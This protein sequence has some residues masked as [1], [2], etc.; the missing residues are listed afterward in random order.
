MIK[1][2]TI[3]SLLVL[4]SCINITTAQNNQETNVE[5]EKNSVSSNILGTG[6][7]IGISYER[8]L[9]ERISLEVGVGLIGF[10]AGITYY[11]IKVVP[12]RL[13][14]YLGAKITTHSMVDGE[15][16]TVAYIPF[17]LTWFS[18]FRMNFGFDVGP[19]VTKHISPGYFGFE[20]EPKSY[21]FTDYGVF[22]NLKVG[23]RF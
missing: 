22:G 10:G 19:A 8:L 15:H 5:I 23:F 9:F 18:N 12:N 1:L 6:S 3:F 17:G 4:I 2:K 7:Y 21:P 14:P 16:K 20:E 11:P 13:R